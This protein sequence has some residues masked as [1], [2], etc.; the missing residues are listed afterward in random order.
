VIRARRL[1]DRRRPIV[2]TATVAGIVLLLAGF[3]LASF[4]PGINREGIDLPRT[5][6]RDVVPQGG[7]VVS[8]DRDGVIRVA[9]GMEPGVPVPTAAAAGELAAQALQRDAALAFVVVA[10]KATRYVVVDHLI[11]ALRQAGARSIYL[12]T[13]RRVLDG[14]E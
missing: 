8:I 9:L 6:A 7:A 1:N 10:D 13:D 2:P 3:A 5:V 14:D 4:R 12:L 11:A